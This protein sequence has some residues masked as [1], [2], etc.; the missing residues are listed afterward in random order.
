MIDQ[1]RLVSVICARA[2]F[3]ALL[4]RLGCLVDSGTEREYKTYA[5][6]EADFVSGA[7]H[8]SDLKPGS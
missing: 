4:T 1:C 3:S 7:L 8:P 2:S 6:L 5:E